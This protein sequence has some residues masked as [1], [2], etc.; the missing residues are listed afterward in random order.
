MADKASVIREA[1]KF[2]AKGQ[3]DRAIAEW[4]KLLPCHDA[5]VYNSIGDL[6][7]KNGDKNKAASNYHQA[8]QIFRQEGFSLKALALYKKILNI[9]PQDARSHLALGELNEEKNIAPDAIKHYL[10]AADM[11]FKAGQKP[12]AVSAYKKILK[13]AGNNLTLRVKI[14]D[15][16]SKEGFAEDTANEYVEIAKLHEA[17]GDLDKARSYLQRS[18]EIKPGN[19]NALIALGSFYEKAGDLQNAINTLKGAVTKTGKSNDLLLKIARMALAAG[20]EAEAKEFA[21]AVVESDPSNLEAKKLLAD[22]LLKT[23]DLQSAW[24]EYAPILDELIF[25]KKDEGALET[26]LLFKETEPVEARRKLITF[27]KQ[28]NRNEE[29][30]SE[31]RQLGEI[32][33]SSG[34]LEEAKGCYQEALTISPDEPDLKNKFSDLEKVPGQSAEEPGETKDEKSVEQILVEAEIFIGYGLHEDAKKL[35][36]KLRLRDPAN[37]QLHL[38]LKEV[39]KNTGDK[40]QAVTECIILSE[41]YKRAGDQ[42]SRQAIIN[43][44]FGINPEDPR[45]LERF[46]QPSAQTEISPEPAARKIEEKTKEAEIEEAPAAEPEPQVLK[47]TAKK[48]SPAEEKPEIPAPASRAEDIMPEDIMPDIKTPE[49]F[50]DDVMNFGGGSTGNIEEFR[51]DLSEADFYL[52][53]ELFEEAEAIYKKVL[54]NFPDNEEVRGKLREIQELRAEHDK[55]EEEH[56][57]EEAA[58]LAT[59]SLDDILSDVTDTPEEAAEPKV[60]NEV[61]EIF[62][63]FKKGLEKELQAEDTE[64]RYNLGIAYREMGLFDDAIREFQVAKH[65]PKLFINA[66]TMLGMCYMEK[67]L[68]PLAIEALQSALMKV[69]RKEESHWGLKYDLALAY[70]RSGQI[71]E[72][73]DLYT[74]VYGWDSKFREVEQ[75]INLYRIKA[76]PR[77]KV[78]RSEPETVEPLEVEPE[79][80]SKPKAPENGSKD[81]NR[82]NRVS[83]I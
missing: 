38:K 13:I 40:E 74:E 17:Q 37:L 80:G 10:T 8:S 50:S 56:A 81:I 67:N 82:K 69:S 22:L 7:L 64:T 4:E 32:L 39:Y 31:L 65:D 54:A 76:E 75:K 53:Q 55:K 78:E 71:K 14:A 62:E 27:Y 58:E 59:V 24:K 2:L 43:E 18:I 16:F 12:D 11:F 77:R 83:Y 1:Q 79:T 72:A 45:V 30:L 57:A 73:F 44:T 51:E 35:L 48:R 63:E 41:L 6:Y 66:T 29:A 34:M 21:G 36:E 26:L 23:G 42:A 28:Q 15:L 19:R 25:V 52:K 46:G 9:N 49:S 60:E 3:I 61:L 20:N 68:Y 47:E 5:N 33:E 70:E